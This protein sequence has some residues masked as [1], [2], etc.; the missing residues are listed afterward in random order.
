LEAGW[1]QRKGEGLVNRG[2]DPNDLV[3]LIK[4]HLPIPAAW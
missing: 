4:G 2:R 3:V 1:K